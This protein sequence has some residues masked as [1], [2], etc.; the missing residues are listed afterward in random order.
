MFI[1]EKGYILYKKAK[2]IISLLET[3]TLE[4]K[5]KSDSIKGSIKIGAS[6][7]I[8]EYILPNFYPTLLKSIPI[9]ILKLL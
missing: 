8:G 1:T 2:E 9:L 6:F 4:M 7:T 5:N 3:T